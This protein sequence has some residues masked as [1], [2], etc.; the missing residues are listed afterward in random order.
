MREVLHLVR[1]REIEIGQVRDWDIWQLARY[2]VRVTR[3]TK[4]I[5][6]LRERSRRAKAPAV[7]LMSWLDV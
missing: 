6:E 2:C 5:R 3:L 1:K 4:E 7:E